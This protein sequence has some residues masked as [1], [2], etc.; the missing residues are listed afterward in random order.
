[1]VS[2]R[3]HG[4]TDVYRMAMNWVDW[5]IGVFVVIQAVRG[6]SRGALVQV[7]ALAGM[8]AGYVLGLWIAPALSSAITHAH[9]RSLLALAIVVA[10]T[11]VTSH[12]GML[13]GT[14][15][16]QTLRHLKVGII[17]SVAGVA[18]G[19]AET[20]VVC[21]LF[22]GL[23]NATSWGGLDQGIQQSQIIAAMDRLM[24]P[25]ASIEARVQALFRYG[26]FPS[27]FSSV[28]TPTVPGATPSRLG[29]VVTSLSAPRGV[30]KVIASGC[31][32]DRQG[33]AFFIGPHVAVTN[34]H[35][36]AGSRHVTVGGAVAYVASFDALN[37]VAVLRV[38]SFS[39]PSVT[40]VGNSPAPG[41]SA[42]VVGF[43]GDQTRTGAP[44]IL[45][46]EIT[47]Q[48]R[49]IYNGASFDRTVL[50]VDVSVAPGSSGS[51]VFVGSNVAGVIFAKSYGQALTAYAVPAD[52]V[53]RDLAA[54]PRSGVA[55]TGRCLN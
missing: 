45:Q 8:V 13:L 5:V 15:I 16:R 54:T 41:S 34:A 51:P 17:D 30:L 28:V 21:W 10:S 23:V 39:E 40:F 42:R 38:P 12:L 14:S 36:V 32:N 35:V 19:V 55:S 46:G 47:A 22:A 44:A 3:R 27:A 25:L 50:V 43:P 4:V 7:G 9:W 2:V 26:D 48:A 37:D 29:H 11:I 52:V 33:T 18:L 49:D 20:L 53:Q 6:R 31:A 1:M 24:P